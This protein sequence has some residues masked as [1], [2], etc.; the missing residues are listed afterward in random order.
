[1]AEKNSGIRSILQHSF[2]YDLFQWLVGNNKLKSKFIKD[3]LRPSPGTSLFDIGCASGTILNYLPKS[4]RYYGLDLNPNYIDAANKRFADRGTFFCA[5]VNNPTSVLEQVPLNFDCVIAYGLLHHLDNDE[6]NK[7]F[8][9]AD[10]VMSKNGRFLTIDNCYIENQS[11]FAKFF[12][13][14]DRGQNTRTVHEYESLALKTFKK[15]K[16]SILH[17]GLRIPYTLIVMECFKNEK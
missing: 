14:K 17:N 9:L 5:D 3:F 8:A 11:P 13:Q 2:I 6:S 10:K 7:L 4:I 1:M 15:V 12:I 16:T